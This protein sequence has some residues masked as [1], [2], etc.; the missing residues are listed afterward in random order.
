MRVMLDDQ[1]TEALETVLEY[2]WKSEETSFASATGKR[3][4]TH[5]YHD[6]KVLDTAIGRPNQGKGTKRRRRQ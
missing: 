5:I 6:L 2:Y 3:A 1:E 4:I